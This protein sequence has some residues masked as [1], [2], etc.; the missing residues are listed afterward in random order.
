MKKIA[1]FIMAIAS[2]SAFAVNGNP[3]VQ[4]NEVCWYQNTYIN[5][6]RYCY[7]YPNSAFVPWVGDGNND[8]WS[9]V[10]VG[11]NVVVQAFSDQNYGGTQWYINTDFDNFQD[12]FSNDAISSFKI[13]PNI[14]F[15]T[16][17]DQTLPNHFPSSTHRISELQTTLS[18]GWVGGTYQASI[19]YYHNDGRFDAYI[20]AAPYTKVVEL[21]VE[22]NKIKALRAKYRYGNYISNAT[23]YVN[24]NLATSEWEDGY[25]VKNPKFNYYEIKNVRD[26]LPNQYDLNTSLNTLWFLS[27]IFSYHS[28][29]SLTTQDGYWLPTINF[30]KNTTAIPTNKRFIFR[31]DSSS[32]VS[33]EN[34]FTF[35]Q[36]VNYEMIYNGT[37]WDLEK[38]FDN[39]FLTTN[40][41]NLPES[42]FLNVKSITAVMGGAWIDGTPN[43]S[44]D[45]LGNGLYNAY[46]NYGNFSKVTVFR[47]GNGKIK[48]IGAKYRNGN[49]L[50]DA[51]DY[52]SAPIAG[53]ATAPGYGLTNL[54]VRFQGK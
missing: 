16:T 33:F 51:T 15:V 25:G 49:Y 30:P 40:G 6:A 5:G 35:E 19:H 3:P 39:N 50:R 11:R 24:V 43:V 41:S 38:R 17:A 14:N 18:G 47:I 37:N 7:S 2:S 9:S 53:S 8:K 44:I 54:V 52:I 48:I 45:A 29:V 34:R 31:S 26:S 27:N 22:G 36:S 4:P 12:N 20:Y 42:D 28:N 1:F 46:V 21:K 10:E 32:T 13:S 23:D